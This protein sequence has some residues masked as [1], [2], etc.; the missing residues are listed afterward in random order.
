MLATLCLISYLHS[1]WPVKFA[2][3]KVCSFVMA[4]LEGIYYIG[5]ST[6]GYISIKELFE[7]LIEYLEALDDLVFPK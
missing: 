5:E 3:E 1:E 4:I 7:P 2:F 6:N